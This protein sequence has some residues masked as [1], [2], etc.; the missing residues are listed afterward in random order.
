MGKT[1]D[2]L[3]VAEAAE[4]LRLELAEVRTLIARGGL[5][6]VRLDAAE[7]PVRH[8]SE[9]RVERRSVMERLAVQEA[10]LRGAGCP[11]TLAR[12]RDA[13]ERS[14]PAGSDQPCGAL[15][16][17]LVLALLDVAPGEPCPGADT[18]G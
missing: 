2:V 1:A 3:T 4:L 12:G 10:A 16:A 8:D 5:R 7:G 13:H 14:T 11:P 6:A 18:Q 9:V 15:C 17:G